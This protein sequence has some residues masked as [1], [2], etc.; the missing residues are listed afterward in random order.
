VRDRVS[1]KRWSSKRSSRRTHQ[2]LDPRWVEAHVDAFRQL[3]A[4][5]LE[6]R[7]LAD[8]TGLGDE[9]FQGYAR[10][11]EALERPKFDRVAAAIGSVD[12]KAR[13]SRASASWHGACR[14]QTCLIS[15]GHAGTEAR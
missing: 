12:R 8:L 3:A 1:P 10:A 13:L 5:D 15:S 11:Q 2:R 14:S 4:A 6:A 9:D 7:V